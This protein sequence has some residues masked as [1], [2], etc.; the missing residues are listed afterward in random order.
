MI[1]TV[2]P[3][4]CLDKTV[5]VQKFD[6][7]STN[8]VEVLRVDRAGKGINV[9]KA[10]RALG[11]DVLC[12]GFDFLEGGA[13]VLANELTALGIRSDFVAR[14]GA[15]RVCT[16]VFEERTRRMIEFNERGESA[17]ETDAEALLLRVERAARACGTLV[18]SGSLPP[19]MPTDFYAR[20][21]RVA[22]AAAP[23]CRVAVD[24]DGEAM[25]LALAERPFFIKPN[26]HE[27]ESTFD[28]KIRDL[29]QLDR[30]AREVLECYGLGMICVSMGGDGA[31]IA[32]RT[33]ACFAKPARV[34]VRSLQGAGDC[35]VA[36]ICLAL[37]RGLPL[38]DILRYGVAA[39]GA[40]VQYE[41]TQ[42][43]TRADFDALLAA[44]IEVTTLR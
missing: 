18:L 32:D 23:Q 41:G 21:V 25:R 3:N 6:P 13:P 17:T 4:P 11:A 16:K 40:A 20:C 35:M 14:T 37:E 5:S 30:K 7:D 44:G 33:G 24:A 22:Y 10:L 26:I 15:L 36:G 1:A 39:S 27:F 9:A 19:G 31:Y 2:T 8:R 38:A 42:V 34:T 43:G 28:C 12:T 29:T